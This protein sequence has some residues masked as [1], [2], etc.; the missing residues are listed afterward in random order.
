MN[1]ILFSKSR[2]KRARGKMAFR[3]ALKPQGRNHLTKVVIVLLLL[4]LITPFASAQQ[5]SS[6]PQPCNL[7][8]VSDFESQCILPED[9]DNYYNEE[10]E[11][12]IACQGSV[13]TYTASANTGTASVTG[14]TWEVA[15]GALTSSGSTAIVTWG[16]GNQGQ[17][18][19]TVVTDSGTTCTLTQN[20]RLIEKPI[21]SVVTTPAYVEMPN[22]DK[23]I[24][25]CKGETVEFT[26]LSSTTNTD[27]VG[28]YW[29]S[30]F[31]DITASTPNFRIE[32]VWHDDDEIHHRVYNNC[33]CYDEE[34]YIIK[35]M[36][37]EILDLGCF[38]TV[39]Q[40]AVVTYTAN[41]PSCNQ[42]SW[43]VE[44]GTIIEGQ[45]Q[46]KVTVRWDNPQNGYG[47][48]G[49]DGNLCG[50]NA[51]PSMLSK[52]I[53]I[54]ENGITIKGQDIVCVDEAVVYSVP[55]YGST[56]YHWNIQPNT[57]V[58]VFEVNGA[59][60]KMIEFEQPGIYQISVS[61]KCDFLECGE[62]TS[63]P[64]TVVVKPRLSI[65]GRERICVHSSCALSTTPA[66]NVSWTIQ[67]ISSNAVIHNSQGTDLAYTFN[68]T[69]KYLITATNNYYCKPATFVLT[70]QETPPAP[71]A[72][73]LDPNS[74]TRACLGSSIL[75]NANPT[76]PDYSVVWVP[77]CS[78]ASPDTVPGNQVT[79]TYDTTEVC[80]IWV[81]NYDRI[82]G[83]LSDSHYVHPVTVY[84]PLPTHL[85]DTL[86]VCP[87]T[88][89]VFDSTDV[90]YE[91]G[92][93]YR[94][95]MQQTKQYCASVQGDSVDF[96]NVRIIVNNQPTPDTFFITLSR[97]F[98]P[99]IE[100]VDTIYFVVK[101][102]DTTHIC[103]IGDTVVCEGNT[104]TF[105]GVFC[106]NDSLIDSGFYWRIEDSVIYNVNNV[107]YRFNDVGNATVQ[108]F[109]RNYNYCTNEEYLS[110]S[111]KHIRVVPTPQI[112]GFRLNGN[113]NQIELVPLLDP[114]EYT[115]VWTY[116]NNSTSYTGN[117]IPY[118]GNGTYSC[119][120][121]RRDSAC[122]NTYTVVYSGSTPP[123]TCNDIGLTIVG[124][125][126]CTQELTLDAAH[127]NPNVQWGV[128]LG[129]VGGVSYT[130]PYRHRA[131]YKLT[132]LGDYIFHASCN[133]NPCYTGSIGYTL[134][135]IPDFTIEKKCESIVII[136]NSKYLDGSKMVY[137]KVNSN[138]ISF[139]VSTPR[140]TVVTPPGT[141]TV[142]LA[143]FGSPNSISNCIIDNF[144]MSNVINS[145]LSITSP[146]NDQTCDNTAMN[147]K[148]QL[149]PIVSY[150]YI[151][152][153]FGDSS[154]L[155]TTN[156]SVSHTY[157][158]GIDTLTVH[159]IN[160]Y[161][162]K[163]TAKKII[164]SAQDNLKQG[165]IV[166][167][168]NNLYCPYSGD[169]K[170]WFT[171]DNLVHSVFY[172]GYYKWYTE[173][174]N[175]LGF[176]EIFKPDTTGI[177]YEYISDVNHC[178]VEKNRNIA[179]KNAPTAVVSTSGDA[180][181][182]GERI[183]LYGAQSPDTNNYAFQWTVTHN[184]LNNN[185][186]NPV[187]TNNPTNAT[188]SFTPT[189]A[190]YYTLQVSISANG[191][192]AVGQK[193]IY[194]NPTPPAPSISFGSNS[195]IDNPPVILSGSSSATSQINWSNGDVG[196]TAY[197]FTPGMATAWYYDP[198]TGCKSEEAKIHI[199]P[200]PDFDALL[201]GCYEK[202][203]SYFET[204]PKLP[205]WGL[206]SGREDI[207]W[208]WL[209][210]T[211]N[212][213]NGTVSYPDYSLS[214]P[215][216]GFGDYNLHL[217]Y[218]N[219]ICGTLISPTLTINPKDTCDCQGLDVSYKYEW[220]VE[221]CRIIYD[222]DVTVCNNSTMDDCLRSLEYL[223]N[224]EYIR[225]VYTDFT[226]TSIAPNDCYTF[227][228]T[229]EASQFVPSST[230]SFRIYDRCHNCTTDFSIDLMPD[231][232]E[233]E[234]DIQLVSFDINPEL[235]SNV[236]AYFD[237]KFDVSPCQNLIA[238]WSEPPMVINY[239]YD[240]AAMVQGLGMVNYATLTQM[241]A[242]GGKVCF[243]AITCEGDQLCKRMYCIPAEEILHIL[244][245][246]G[247]EPRQTN[248]GT[249]S[250]EDKGAK[251]MTNPETGNL[252]DPRLMPNPTTGEV[253]VIGTTDE[254]VEVLVMDMNG[255][256][257]ATFEN[258]ANFN[259]STLSSG[260]YIVRV[261]TKHDN[262]ET[263][264]Y[265]KLVKK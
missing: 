77:I 82:L 240:G 249:S 226:N 80:D 15:G 115:F 213:A 48:I 191:C 2:A 127:Y 44:G 152:W 123:A 204:N 122:S 163:L 113:S 28:Y 57:G 50:D 101:G 243:Y 24:Y 205:V 67:K 193:K 100:Y 108:L 157:M 247:I 61:Y 258:T 134:D 96:P 88:E 148:I 224:E 104:L 165:E 145:T 218:N 175:V 112:A 107:I 94:W 64:L 83:C 79:I 4:F 42:Y 60:K 257:M 45:D 43:Y 264:T 132:D 234:M 8:I 188:N 141:Y 129:R 144:T 52:K 203:R 164:H 99:N 62:F 265:L 38:G 137:I 221:E 259:I 110:S 22:G 40:D 230:I 135:F 170:A 51:C 70:V 138:T 29:E 120:I 39:C 36:E 225:V 73:D 167:E 86:I 109:Y 223:F 150:Q 178:R 71:T 11:I 214:L 32:N 160:E 53:P 18:T 233:C 156:D 174:N 46:P 172:G 239:W 140:Y 74:P 66:A 190:G 220:R 34:R 192:P 155:Q 231:K 153:I 10:P 182:A 65:I 105:R 9:K 232:F 136:N 227:H 31:Y 41:S 54:I 197:Y 151:E 114:N 210:N 91:N 124:I 49:L 87:G 23:V 181:C 72:D 260:I 1:P 183:M 169:K 19:V 125:N 68:Q 7:S 121:T 119:T 139:P 21:I 173:P 184:G 244:Q 25:V 238:F 208:K 142:E 241:I 166:E 199:E 97:S 246:M 69:G 30:G 149:N 158:Q 35:V 179:F 47:I 133:S 235:S 93:I 262:T 17:I 59:N 209:F 177:Y 222:V 251:Q 102:A 207:I 116:N 63:E 37:G 98:C 147:L 256:K 12:I 130:N 84:T 176:A 154:S 117:H 118:Q 143:G 146:W 26:D 254:V 215:L 106:W 168:D 33:G 211:N 216:Q 248:D 212:I 95:T 161:G 261:K 245:E 228:L 236:A 219:G 201:T 195:C 56:E 3:F 111:I 55:L 200:Q 85:P 20:V 76:N 126:Y 5:V 185:L 206:T 58:S 202:C 89:I 6:T 252:T 81:F 217:D 242:E 253:N 250:N 196:S 198:N 229:I 75:L 90:P 180:F 14:W 159:V 131:T 171:I 237:F 16:N 78:S 263:I 128:D 92:M 189:N 13:V 103:I 187:T 255:R 162:C 27:I 186:S 194:V